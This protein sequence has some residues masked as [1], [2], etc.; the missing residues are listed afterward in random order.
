MNQFKGLNKCTLAYSVHELNCTKDRA[1][2]TLK[3]FIRDDLI[4]ADIPTSDPDIREII[5]FHCKLKGECMITIGF[6]EGD[7]T[8]QYYANLTQMSKTEEKNGR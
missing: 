6:N 2:D 3:N 8:V 7:N 5:F 4:V 1:Y